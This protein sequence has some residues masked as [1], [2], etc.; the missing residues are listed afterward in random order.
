MRY[1]PLT[2][3]NCRRY[4]TE[5]PA[6]MS[7]FWAWGLRSLLRKE[8]A[9]SRNLARG[10]RGASLKLVK[11]LKRAAAKSYRLASRKRFRC[12]SAR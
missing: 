3:F 6:M 7:T 10:P 4:L 12:A 5:I 1:Q 9:S 11:A 2:N 8:P